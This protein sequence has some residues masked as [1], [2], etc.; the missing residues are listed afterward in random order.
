MAIDAA[1]LPPMWDKPVITLKSPLTGAV[2]DDFGISVAVDGSRVVVG[3]NKDS[4]NADGSGCVYVYD[5]SNGTPVPLATLKNPNPTAKSL[6]GSSIAI[7]G[8]WLVVGDPLSLSAPLS[9]P[10]VAYV[11]D[12]RSDTPSEPVATL[13]SPSPE[14]SYHFATSVAISGTRVVVGAPYSDDNSVSR[15]GISYVYDLSSGTPNPMVPVAILHN[16][17]PQPDDLFG[18][19]VAISGTRAVVATRLGVYVYDLNNGTPTVPTATLTIP[20]LSFSRV[21]ISDMRVVVGASSDSTGARGAGSAYVFDLN[22]GTPTVPALMLNNPSPGEFDSFGYAVAISGTRVVVG[23]PGD[24]PDVYS[25][26]QGSAYVYGLSGGSGTM[27]MYPGPVSGGWNRFGHSVAISGSIAVISALDDNSVYIYG[28]DSIVTR[29][30]VLT[31]P[32]DGA[33]T[34]SPVM[35]SFSLPENALP[36]SVKLSFGGTILT[37]AAT[38][39]G[40][41]SHSFNFDPANPTASPYIASGQ[42]I[43]R[44]VY[45]VTLAYRDAQGNPIASDTS[46]HVTIGTLPLLL[47]PAANTKPELP[48]QVSYTLPEAPKAGTVKLA[49]GSH[50]L[51]MSARGEKHDSGDIEFSFDPKNPTAS[52]YIASGAPIPDGVYT[53]TLS[54]QDAQG[55]VVASA[56]SSGV[57]IDA[58]TLPP[59]LLA[60]A[61]NTTAALP[62]QVSYT[63]PEAPKAGTVKLAFGPHVF[64]MSA[65]GEVFGGGGGVAFSFDPADP[66]ASPYIASGSR[67]PDGVY[68]VS[69]SY[70]DTAG[71][72]VASTT[73]VNVTIDVLLADPTNAIL[74]GEGSEVPAS[75][76]L[77]AEAVWRKFG[78]PAVNAA[79][80]VVFNAEWADASGRG[81]AIFETNS[82]SDELKVVIQRGVPAP[83]PGPGVD[84]L[85]AEVVVAKLRDPI[86]A[87]NGDVLTPVTLA[88]RGISSANDAALIWSPRSNFTEARLVVREGQ[89]LAGGKVKVITAAEVGSA[90]VAFTAT[91]AGKGITPT[92]HSIACVWTPL[93][94]IVPVAR[95]GQVID[96]M[97]GKLKHFNTLGTWGSSPGN[98]RGMASL[99]GTPLKLGFLGKS[100]GGPTVIL[101]LEPSGTPEFFG[102]TDS[103]FFVPS[104]GGFMV[105]KT[106]GLPAWADQLTSPVYLG[107]L[108]NG[109]KGIFQ[110]KADT[111]T[112]QPV[113]TVGEEIESD[114][115]LKT[116]KDPVVSSDGTRKGWVGTVKGPK[117]TSANDQVIAFAD[118]TNLSI[119][120][121]EGTAAVDAPAGSRWKSLLSL[122]MPARGPL[123]LGSLQRG[124][125]RITSANDVGVWGMDGTGALHCLFREGDM[126][127]GRKLKTHTVLKAVSGT[128]G[129][130][131]A[132][133]DAGQ[134]VWLATF[135]DGSTAI[136]KTQVP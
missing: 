16:P 123:F 92:N 63:L 39:E 86:V 9:A 40:A 107:T 2:Y 74:F 127:G 76:G 87:A 38:Q 135:T 73:N 55:N 57:R 113:A 56:T 100:S 120:A 47:A 98:G 12:L 53:V 37:L 108:K 43:P 49:F 102:Y 118:G 20:G 121:R 31:A 35:V 94:G 59:V 117:V 91:L 114:L 42:P 85:P 99:D 19:S 10:G 17:S 21:A 44:G 6:F 78:V 84:P 24:S 80:E 105:L 82:A 103:A 72:A 5:L 15:A 23:T 62:V 106:L 96:G 27:L 8:R 131:R 14:S 28:P 67:V 88:G 97:G 64:T 124:P 111:N 89:A 52:P 109:T 136:I 54:Y 77:P 45:A 75:A 122:A 41:G 115:R 101:A 79:G 132:W 65:L 66:T 68:A 116:A 93:G 134:V 130:T 129:V 32:A 46:S 81:A 104:I 7:S 71:N 110:Y 83:T 125:G 13:N 48:L 34:L 90:G 95:E 112:S 128:P 36:G 25:H 51:T 18:N 30:P 4:T 133:N 22:S 126:I 26:N 3:A 70:Q 29:S 33:H 1:T 61:A 58:D 69:L 119:V 11:Y 50:V 60:P